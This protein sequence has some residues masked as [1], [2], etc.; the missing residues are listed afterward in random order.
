MQDLT[1]CVA[2]GAVGTVDI[3]KDFEMIGW[4]ESSAPVERKD[5]DISPFKL[6]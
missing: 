3:I 1:I 4:I 2:V 5:S 6:D